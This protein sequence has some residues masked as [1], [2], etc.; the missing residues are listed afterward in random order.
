[1]NVYLVQH[2]IMPDGENDFPASLRISATTT[3]GIF[4]TKYAAEL[5][6]RVTRAEA[7]DPGGFF[8][9]SEISLVTVDEFHPAL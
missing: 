7:V 8:R 5:A 6:D 9:V 4:S 1:M 3:V 2:K